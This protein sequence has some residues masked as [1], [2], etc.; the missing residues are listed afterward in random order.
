MN[1]LLTDLRKMNILKLCATLSCNTDNCS[2]QYRCAVAMYLLS[3]L[4]QKHSIRIERLI[5]APGNG[6]GYADSL[7][8]VDKQYLK[9]IMMLIKTPSKENCD[10]NKCKCIQ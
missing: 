6:K 2:K 10:T 9:K 4:D 3:M 7:N 8:S 1:L 5:G